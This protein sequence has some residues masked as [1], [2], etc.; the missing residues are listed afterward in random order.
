MRLRRGR[1]THRPCRRVVDSD[2]RERP[3]E[4]E[5]RIARISRIGK[6]H[7][8]RSYP[9]SSVVKSFP[10]SRLPVSIASVVG[11]RAPDWSA[12]AHLSHV[13]S[14]GR[15]M[16]RNAGHGGCSACGKLA[17]CN[18]PAGKTPSEGRRRDEMAVRRW[19]QGRGNT[20]LRTQSSWWQTLGRNQFKSFTDLSGRR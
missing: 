4:E 7:F 5:P 16:L 10:L 13:S 11:S 8:C 12:I 17:C 18:D 20:Q 14:P 6:G 19:F 1:P 3:N 15:P 2:C 9:C